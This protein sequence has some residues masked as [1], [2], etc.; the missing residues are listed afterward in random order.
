M[1]GIRARLA[2]LPEEKRRYTLETLAA[3]LA[4]A[5]RYDRLRMLFDDDG[6]LHARVQYGGF[7]YDGYLA[8][9][10]L[11]WDRFAQP[12]ARAGGEEESTTAA[13]AD[14]VRFALLRT[15]LNSVAGNNPPAIVVRAVETGVWSPERALATAARVPKPAQRAML[16][17]RLLAQEG[18][19]DDQRGRARTDALTA[20]RAVDEED[21]KLET[22][23]VLAPRLTSEFAQQALALARSVAKERRAAALAAVAPLFSGEARSAILAEAVAAAPEAQ[24]YDPSVWPAL[25]AALD[26]MADAA[27]IRQAIERVRKGGRNIGRRKAA[28]LAALASRIPGPE[29]ARAAAE[30]LAALEREPN[31]KDRIY[32]L[33]DTMPHLNGAIRRQAAELG[34]E[35]A[36]RLPPIDQ[37][38]DIPQLVGLLAV[39]PA[40]EASELVRALQ[41][42]RDASRIGYVRGSVVELLVAI[43]QRLDG[44]EHDAV[45]REALALAE[46][47]REQGTDEG[48]WEIKPLLAVAHLLDADT[49]DAVIRKALARALQLPTLKQ[50]NELVNP[51]AGALTM[52]APLLPADLLEDSYT[53]A[54]RVED[55]DARV[56]ALAAFAHCLR[57]PARGALLHGAVGSLHEIGDGGVRAKALARLAPML[58]IAH[59]AAALD[60]ALAIDIE[61][62]R[63]D[64]LKA[65]CPYLPNDLHDKAL[66]GIRAIGFEPARADALGA[67]VSVLQET[68]LA[69]VLDD[70]W[71]IEWEPG[72]TQCVAAIAARLPPP[73]RAE[74]V[75]AA[76]DAYR[77]SDNDRR[78]D[79]LLALA[80]LLVGARAAEGFRL[81][82]ALD[83]D[84]G[85]G[86]VLAAL[87]PNIALEDLDRFVEAAADLDRYQRGVFAAVGP[88]L[89]VRLQARALEICLFDDFDLGR[90]DC[91]I[92]LFPYLDDALRRRA[93]EAT[94]RAGDEFARAIAI[95]GFSPHLSGALVDIAAQAATAI[96]EADARARALAALV[97]RVEGEARD[98]LR[99]AC[100]DAALASEAIWPRAH[101]LVRLA[102]QPGGKR[103]AAVPREA[104]K[105]AR[106]L[107]RARKYE[108]PGAP[109]V[110]LLPVLRGRSLA[111]GLK[112]L[113]A[114]NAATRA[115]AFAQWVAPEHP[116]QW[117]IVRRA[118]AEHLAALRDSDR[119][120]VLR[121]LALPIFAPPVVPADV[122]AEIGRTT[123]EIS[124][125]WTWP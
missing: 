82:L 22:L 102:T 113:L 87:A 29:H 21:E 63:G 92:A 67:L 61:L 24:S 91:V 98:R 88:R 64:A 5:D 43:A 124:T 8:D 18:L 25:A 32:M 26:P 93:L 116:A 114:I 84:L 80:P 1:N 56:L 47:P 58:G 45:V 69:T 54:R 108:D 55:G 90:A 34:L 19:S 104:L 62:E 16:L 53:A 77:K 107:A 46:L 13:L 85:R 110:A 86:N 2:A 95:E 109:L 15:S 10:A 118:V 70:A 33:P 105:A 35:T 36:L 112:S 14:V 68:R 71:A 89:D 4:A 27:L 48:E 37:E 3:H 94:A 97:G 120:A 81:A 23:A 40:L 41:A 76:L 52:L 83:F 31:D 9:L 65:V 50:R 57:D 42:V 106:R 111:A 39:V 74:V 99:Q 78:S 123:S 51:R 20:L 96:D 72:R 121:I 11:A 59:F 122:V 12:R 101:A 125:K 79:M 7:A 115:K 103:P 75:D 49:R 117:G 60:A 100:L 119:E 73:R 17:A 38:W 44:A 28:A 30:A 66:Q 6:W